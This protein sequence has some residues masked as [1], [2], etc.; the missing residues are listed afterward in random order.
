MRWRQWQRALLA[1]SG[2]SRYQKLIREQS[3][4]LKGGSATL[5]F[6]PTLSCPHTPLTRTRPLRFDDPSMYVPAPTARPHLA[7]RRA[8]KKKALER[9]GGAMCRKQGQLPATGLTLFEAE[10]SPHP[11]NALF[12]PFLQSI[13]Q[14]DLLQP[15]AGVRFSPILPLWPPHCTSKPLVAVR[16]PLPLPLRQLDSR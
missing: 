14:F 12:P 3:R 8:G 11:S 9:L 13:V 16:K 6:L 5:R 4:Q 7:P 1:N 15:N 2:S 10:S